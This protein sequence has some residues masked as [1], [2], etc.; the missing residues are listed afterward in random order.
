MVSWTLYS[1]LLTLGMSR[2]AAGFASAA[3]LSG[4]AEWGARRLR[5]PVTLLVV[6]AI[7]PLVPGADAYF[8]MMAFLSGSDQEGL[9]MAVQTILAA[10]SIAS[11]VVAAA[12]VWRARYYKQKNK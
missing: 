2:F 8:A 7:I 5:V 3:A 4:L 1:S 10:L 11:G 9:G 6:P 12:T